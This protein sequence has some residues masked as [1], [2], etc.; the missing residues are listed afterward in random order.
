MLPKNFAKPAPDSIARDGRSLS[1]PDCER[2]AWAI[3]F[4]IRRER[5]PQSVAFEAATAAQR[6]EVG[7]AA[8]RIDQALSR[9]RPLRRRAFTT[10]RPA[11]VDIR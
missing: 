5:D 2:D 8:A 1:P 3:Q 9:C 7:P 4:W 11:R 6:C 10:A